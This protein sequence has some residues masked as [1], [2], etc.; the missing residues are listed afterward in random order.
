MVATIVII[1]IPCQAEGK[2]PLTL[3]CRLFACHAAAK[4]APCRRHA[5]PVASLSAT[6]LLPPPPP[7]CRRTARQRCAAATLL[8]FLGRWPAATAAVALPPTPLSPSFSSFLLSLSSSPFL[9]PLLSLLLVDCCLLSVPPP[10][11][12]PPVSLSPPRRVVVERRR[13]GAIFALHLRNDGLP[14]ASSTVQGC[15]CVFLASSYRWV[16]VMHKIPISSAH[17]LTSLPYPRTR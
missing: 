6:R 12:L 5:A 17:L 3:R 8:H 16:T 15:V 11:L 7:P 9:S 14:L 13:Q 4:P 10:S 1:L 2:L